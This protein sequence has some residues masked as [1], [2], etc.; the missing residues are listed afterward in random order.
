MQG[1]S[2]QPLFSSLNRSSPNRA[3]LN[4]SG[5]MNSGAHNAKSR[6]RK[7]NLLRPVTY[8]SRSIRPYLQ[9]HFLVRTPVR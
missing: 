3:H 1:K 5:V 6:K 7:K 8:S 4:L 2:F 9:S